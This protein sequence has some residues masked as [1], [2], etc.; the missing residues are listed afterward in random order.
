[1]IQTRDLVVVP[2]RLART[3]TIADLHRERIGVGG[4]LLPLR[5]LIRVPGGITNISGL[6]RTV[7]SEERMPTAELRALP[8]ACV[9]RD[10]Q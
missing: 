9:S 7:G 3:L 1:M 2:A 5:Y 6:F 10:K 8:R 4:E